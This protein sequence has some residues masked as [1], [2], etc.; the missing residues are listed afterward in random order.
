M[1]SIIGDVCE[2][3][4]IECAFNK[5]KPK[6]EKTLIGCFGSWSRL[7]LYEK[8]RLLVTTSQ[9]KKSKRVV[10]ILK[11]ATHILRFRTLRGQIETY[12]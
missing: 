9:G 12:L 10:K 8:I 7:Y 5:R 3:R 1:T 6:K 11:Y 4:R 2:R